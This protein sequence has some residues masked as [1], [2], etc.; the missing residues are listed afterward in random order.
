VRVWLL[1]RGWLPAFGGKR[2]G[3]L[4][5]SGPSGFVLTPSPSWLLG[6]VFVEGVNGVPPATAL[7]A[8]FTT[9]S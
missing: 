4:F 9:S 6:G 1:E 8:I 7:R 2:Y 5:R 3:N